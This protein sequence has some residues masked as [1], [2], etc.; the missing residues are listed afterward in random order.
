MPT[1]KIRNKDCKYYVESSL[2]EIGWKIN[3]QIQ[4]HFDTREC[5]VIY[6]NIESEIETNLSYKQINY[7]SILFDIDNNNDLP[8]VVEPI[9]RTI[10]NKVM[11]SGAP[12]CDSF[13]FTGAHSTQIGNSFRIE[14][15]AR[16][17]QEIG[18][19]NGIDEF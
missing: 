9:L 14:M 1:Y 3:D 12:H 15:I 6:S 7:I 8:Y 10:T 17:Y 16:Y 4:E 13:V 5:A 19:L 11:T 18:I 2:K